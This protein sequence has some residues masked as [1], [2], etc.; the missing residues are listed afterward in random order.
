MMVCCSKNK[1]FWLQA[2]TCLARW[3]LT[4]YFE[5]HTVSIFLYIFCLHKLASI[6]F[7]F[8]LEEKC[9]KKYVIRKYKIIHNPADAKHQNYSH[10]IEPTFILNY[11]SNTILLVVIY[12]YVQIYIIVCLG[13]LINDAQS[14]LLNIET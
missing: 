8:L 11:K 7:L 14:K 10:M 3:L 4:P 5:N 12:I 9:I 13:W 1:A 6:C 2:T